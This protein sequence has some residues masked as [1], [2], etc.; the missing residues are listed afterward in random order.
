MG[1][2]KSQSNRVIIIKFSTNSQILGK[3]T[4]FKHFH[5]GRMLV[6]KEKELY[7]YWNG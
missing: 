7:F 1:I 3:K 6:P 2:L 5:L 4:N